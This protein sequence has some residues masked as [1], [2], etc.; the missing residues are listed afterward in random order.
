MYPPPQTHLP[1]PPSPKLAPD[2]HHLATVLR[3]YSNRHT[4]PEPFSYEYIF[5]EGKLPLLAEFHPKPR[6]HQPDR[7]LPSQPQV[8]S[9]GKLQRS[10]T[11]K[12]NEKRT[13]F[14]LTPST[15]PTPAPESTS[16]KLKRAFSLSGMR[17]SSPKRSFSQSRPRQ[18]PIPRRISTTATP[19]DSRVPS[20][21]LPTPSPSPDPER[22]SFASSHKDFLPPV[23]Y[24]LPRASW[25]SYDDEDYH[26]LT[27]L[28]EN[29]VGRLSPSPLPTMEFRRDKA[30]AL[31][32]ITDPMS[33]PYTPAGSKAPSFVGQ[34]SRV[35]SR[36]TSTET[37]RSQHFPHPDDTPR[38][39]S[40]PAN[41][42]EETPKSMPA[43]FDEDIITVVQ[44][45][46]IEAPR[47]RPPLRRK[48][49][50]FIEHLDANADKL[51]GNTRPPLVI[52]TEAKA[53]T[54]PMLL[55]SAPRT[56][57]SLRTESLGTSSSTPKHASWGAEV[58][59]AQARPIVATGHGRIISS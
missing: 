41:I 46:T 5:E 29:A 17:S 31:L 10:M 16:D 48:T 47:P 38:A 34:H 53:Q 30:L 19:S 28:R 42:R 52:V 39:P 14:D 13:H 3:A 40:R 44:G 22:S 51:V 21:V 1:A 9:S 58:C 11:S 56:A 8:S 57:G 25:A 59:T 23:N 18:A 43:P 15:I 6:R 50:K 12:R 33:P 2:P 32:G 4:H 24:S 26:D 20:L 49:S 55:H 27:Y 35:S 36:R 45:S 54:E 37:R 7:T